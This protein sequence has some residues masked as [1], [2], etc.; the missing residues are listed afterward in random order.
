MAV[1]TVSAS[2]NKPS[3]APGETMI[4][5]IIYG[6][7]DNQQLKVTIMVEDSQGNKSAPVTIA[8]NIVD[9]LTISVSDVDGRVWTKQSDSGTVA[10][11][12]AVA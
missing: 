5:S 3:Y 8:A 12:R 9:P 11:Y 2:L 7:I 4:L 1:P 10:V 6:D